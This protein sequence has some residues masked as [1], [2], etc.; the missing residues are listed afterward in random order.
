MSTKIAQTLPTIRWIRMMKI[1]FKFLS[2]VLLVFFIAES[3][4]AQNFDFGNR[5]GVSIG[6]ELFDDI[7]FGLEFETRTKNS[8]VSID[9]HLIN[10]DLTYKINSSFRIG[11]A[12]RLSIAADQESQRE[13]GQR[14]STNLRYEYEID[15]FEIKVKT[16][17][18]YSLNEFSSALL[19]FRNEL[20]NRNSVSVDYNWFGTKIT[21]TAAFELFHALNNAGGPITYKY[22]FKSGF[23]YELTSSWD[24]DLF[25]LY[26]H[27]L[28]GV[29]PERFNV[30]GV[31][32]NYEF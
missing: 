14:Y 5:Y 9:K 16:T 29:N 6:T 24:F 3:T 21:P 26:D 19:D 22:R 27:D 28:N 1:N 25:Y 13:L 23:N 17:L 11:I 4:V 31:V 20:V 8:G 7:D 10:P 18:Q 15:D 32:V 12:Y 30:I 2:A